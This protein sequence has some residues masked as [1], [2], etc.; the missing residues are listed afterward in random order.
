MRTFM[1]IRTMQEL[2]TI[3]SQA[4]DDNTETKVI[5][6]GGAEDNLYLEVAVTAELLEVGIKHQGK[7]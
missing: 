1:D 6:T 4:I 5:G 2:R 3:I 7:L